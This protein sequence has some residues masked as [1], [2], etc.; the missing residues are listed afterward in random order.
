ML[1]QET[2]PPLQCRE[3]RRR[4]VMLAIFV[5]CSMANSM[6]WLQY[7]IIANIM[8]R[9][10]NVSSLAINWTSM[11]YM[12]CYIPFV[13]PASWVLDRKG[14]RV[15]LLSG[16]GIMTTGAWLKVLSASPEYFYLAFLGQ[17][18]VGMAQI[19]ILGVPARLAAVWFGPRQV[20]TACALGVFGNQVGVAL[21]FLIPPAVVGNHEDVKD[22]GH[23]LKILYYGMAVAPS[24]M[25]CL[26]LFFF[27]KEPPLP[28]SPAQASLRQQLPITDKST[29]RQTYLQTLKSLLTNRNFVL[30]LFS[31]GI[32]VGVFYVVSTLLNQTVLLYFANAEEDAGRIGLTIVLAGMVGSVTGG[33]ILDKT[34]RFK[35]CTLVVYFMALAGMLAFTFTLTL[36]HIWVIYI[37]AGFLG[38]F[39]TGY[40]GIGYEFAAE[41]TYPIPEGTSSGLLNASSEVFGVIFTLAGG[42]ILGAHGDIATNGTLTALL[43]AGLA[44]TLLIEGK[45]LKRQAAITLRHSHTHLEQEEMLT[46]QT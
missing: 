15:T 13:F 11:I 32:N 29:D 9:Y 24:I 19:F 22:I 33:I 38:F 4:W 42:E 6:H 25:L 8:M 36:G 43:L 5:L 12:A 1:E 3:Y 30:L 26:V 35:E 14:L 46:T 18:L 39:M 20:S 31:Y 34:H 2:A 40:L 37:T 41:L 27:Q 17:A 28:P 44:M 10:Y 16:A 7:S 45:A 23:D 21:G